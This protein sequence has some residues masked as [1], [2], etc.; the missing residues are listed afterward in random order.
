M[1]EEGLK[2]MRAAGSVTIG[3]DEESCVV[4]GMPGVAMATG[5]VAVQLPLARIAGR[6][7]SECR[8]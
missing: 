2:E 6:L 3:Q 5:A 1:R 4:Y 8:L 7:L